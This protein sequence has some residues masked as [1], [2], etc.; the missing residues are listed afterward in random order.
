MSANPENT[1]RLFQERFDLLVASG[2]ANQ[3][4]VM[5][6]KTVIEMVERHY[7]I[8]LDEERGA[9]LASHL[10]VTLKRLL[11]GETLMQVPEVVWQELSGHPDECTFAGIIVT[12]LEEI[13]QFSIARDEAG[14]IAVH[15]CNIKNGLA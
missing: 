10:A 8:Q 3:R 15:L 6:T 14:F 9:F 4:S 11:D 2:Q 7:G 13:L 1:T 5:A 12:E